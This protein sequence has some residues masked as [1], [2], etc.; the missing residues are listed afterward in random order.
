MLIMELIETNFLKE[1]WGTPGHSVPARRSAA[2]SVI[3]PLQPPENQEAIVE[4]I[5]YGE[6]FKPYTSSAFEAYG[7]TSDLFIQAMKGEFE[8]EEVMTEIERI[9]NETLQRDRQP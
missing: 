5:E 1:T 9:A 3:N 8:V 2:E 7:K 4:A 6:V